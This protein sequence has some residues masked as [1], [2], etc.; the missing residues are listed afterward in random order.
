MLRAKQL[1]MK[2][3]MPPTTRRGDAIASDSK[4]PSMQ[5]R[6]L[7]LVY[8]LSLLLLLVHVLRPFVPL[9]WPGRRKEVPERARAPKWSAPKGQPTPKIVLLT[10]AATAVDADADV[11][12]EFKRYALAPVTKTPWHGISHATW[13]PFEV[14]ST[15]ILSRV[16][17]T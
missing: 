13:R 5:S 2:L 1:T 4:S 8:P 16:A 7:G 14:R 3:K 9:L 11:D 12:V 6:Q 10:Q 17:T 15:T